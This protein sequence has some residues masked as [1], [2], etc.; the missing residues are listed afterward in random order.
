MPRTIFL[1]NVSA[2]KMLTCWPIGESNT[3][4]TFYANLWYAVVCC[5][6]LH[7]SCDPG[8]PLHSHGMSLAALQ[9]N[10][11]ITDESRHF[12]EHIPVPYRLP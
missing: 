11:A 4:A 8:I 2:L 10:L 12:L 1:R 9:T 5:V 7:D 6:V 3:R